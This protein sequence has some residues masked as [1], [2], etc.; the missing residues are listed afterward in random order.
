[1]LKSIKP[2]RKRWA[3]GPASVVAVVMLSASCSASGNSGGDDLSSTDITL[4]VGVNPGGGQDAY[5]RFMAPYLGE[6]LGTKVTV[7]NQPGAGTLVA[8]NELAKGAD[9]GSELVLNGGTA[10]ITFPVTQPSVTKY[11][12]SELKYLGRISSEPNVLYARADA[13]FDTIDEMIEQGGFRSGAA[14][15]GSQTY[16]DLLVVYYALGLEPDIISGYQDSGE[17]LLAMVRGE[18]DAQTGSLSSA[19]EDLEANDFKAIAVLDHE[20]AP[21]LPDVPTIFEAKSLSLDED[22]KTVLDTHISILETGRIIMAP[23]GVS[24]ETL[25]ELQD[26]FE[27]VVTDESVIGEAEDENLQIDPLTGQELT[28]LMQQLSTSLP[29]AYTDLVGSVAD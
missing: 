11:D 9:D 2:S 28:E 21:E 24:E 29:E 12:P 17:T 16:T 25:T 6:E 4:T 10:T 5:A 19:L 3:F 27:A 22:Q 15:T 18:I 1:M 20:R 23:P 8:M 14:S 26:A 7:A 13:P